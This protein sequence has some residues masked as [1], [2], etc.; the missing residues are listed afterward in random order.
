MLIQANFSKSPNSKLIS[1]YNTLPFIFECFHDEQHTQWRWK[2][3]RKYRTRKSPNGQKCFSFFFLRRASSNLRDSF[4]MVFARNSSIF[5]WAVHQPISFFQVEVTPGDSNRSLKNY[6]FLYD[7]IFS[8]RV[9]KVGMIICIK[10]SSIHSPYISFLI[11][12]ILWKKISVRGCIL[13]CFMIVPTLFLY[14]L[15]F[16]YPYILLHF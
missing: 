16:C 9:R 14:F 3:S 11:I 6:G 2:A 12:C 4:T 1:R 7:V 13:D 15:P 10:Q 5:H 8:L